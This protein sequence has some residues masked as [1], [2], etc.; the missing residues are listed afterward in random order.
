MYAFPQ[1]GWTKDPETLERMREHGG[2]TLRDYFAAGAL[3]ACI[4]ITGDVPCSSNDPETVEAL[5]RLWETE[6]PAD[7]RDVTIRWLAPE[8]C[9]VGRETTT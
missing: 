2:M 7:L 9:I 3:Q 6:D 8:D 5:K 1:H 4:W